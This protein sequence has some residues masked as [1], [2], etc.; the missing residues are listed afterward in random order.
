MPGIEEV[1]VHDFNRRLMRMAAQEKTPHTATIEVTYGCNLRCAHCFNPTHQAL[2]SEM[3]QEMIFR[4]L[5]DL[6]AAGCVVAGFTGGEIFTRPDV[7]D[8]MAYAK[9]LGLQVNLLTNATLV[10]DEIIRKLEALAP[11]QVSVSVYGMTQETYESVTRVP[12]SFFKFRE[13]VERLKNS[14]LSLHFKMPVM[15]LNVHELDLA[16]E[17]FR[18]EKLPFVHSVEIHPGTDGSLEPLKVR[19]S[20]EIAAGLRLRYEEETGCAGKAHPEENIRQTQKKVF[21]CTCGVSTVAVTPYGEM[22]LCVSNP[23]PRYSLRTGSVRE[24][25]KILVDFVN[26]AEPTEKFECPSCELAPHC[27][28]GAMDAFLET[29]NFN[30]CLPYFKDIAGRMKAAV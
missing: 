18:K 28:Q 25:W 3:K 24:G 10:T 8:L 1:S 20:P 21:S 22:N 17:W 9:G 26:D 2:P 27:T 13:G 15:T 23:Y 29:G 4:I 6:A 19:L 5:E 11:T 14:R 12:G 30:P 7:F 16:Y